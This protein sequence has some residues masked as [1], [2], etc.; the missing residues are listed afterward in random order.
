[1]CAQQPAWLC[2]RPHA[3][4]LLPP[5]PWLAAHA[6]MET[7]EYNLD[8]VREAAE[9]EPSTAR[10]EA[11]TAR[12]LRLRA[13]LPYLQYVRCLPGVSLDSWTLVR[14]ADVRFS[15]ERVVDGVRCVLRGAPSLSPCHAQPA[16]AGP[17]GRGGPRGRRCLQEY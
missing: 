4:L 1:M 9:L 17:A 7:T 14:A 11:L 2:I 12:V 15:L 10:W 16:R 3:Q 6:A 8:D 13:L 5:T